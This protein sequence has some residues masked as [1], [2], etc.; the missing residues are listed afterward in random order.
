MLQP[1]LRLTLQQTLLPMLLAM[2]LTT[3][4]TLPTSRETLPQTQDTMQEL[5]LFQSRPIG[6]KEA[7][8]IA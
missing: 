8:T 1:S 3:Q 4:P 2:P 5:N 6:R 7:N